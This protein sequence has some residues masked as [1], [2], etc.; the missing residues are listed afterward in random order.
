[1]TNRSGKFFVITT[2]ILISLACSLLPTP[3]PEV[4][5]V[6]TISTS[7]SGTLAAADGEEALDTLSDSTLH[8]PDEP[9]PS[10]A[11]IELAPTNTG[12][13][14]DAP[15]HLLRVAYLKNNDV[16]FWEEGSAPLQLTTSG[17]VVEVI[18]SDDYRQAVF[19]IQVDD[20]SQAIWAANTDAS[21]LWGVVTATDF[22]LMS[23]SQ[24]TEVTVP[25]QIDWVPGTHRIAFNTRLIQQGPGLLLQD[26]LWMVDT[27]DPLITRSVL[28]PG[29]GGEFT[30]SRDGRKI[31]IVRP[32]QIT[33]YDSAGS[34]RRDLHGF[35]PVITESEYQYYPPVWW[36]MDSSALRAAIPPRNP[37]ADPPL[38]T[39]IYHFP[40]DGSAPTVLSEIITK[41]VMENEPVLSPDSNKVAYVGP[42]YT[43][44]PPS[45]GL[46]YTAPVESTGADAYIGGVIELSA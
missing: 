27:D 10:V 35:F 45:W 15:S 28:P 34:V 46:L 37:R 43:G 41:P 31:A 9:E 7:V 17:N 20:T 29:E 18:L 44:D 2:L 3:P 1:M 39:R 30:Y 16:W 8:P 19:V 26:D 21:D 23:S 4:D 33:I 13:P 40:A 24:G 11:P 25:Y 38:A 6:D 14:F 22:Q 12:E 32:D 36:T 5:T 42:G